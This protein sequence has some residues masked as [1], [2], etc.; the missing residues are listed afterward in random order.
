MWAETVVPGQAS[1]AMSPVDVVRGWVGGFLPIPSC[2]G[3][4]RGRSPRQ[5]LEDVLADALAQP[6]CLVTFSGGRDSSL[7]L[8]AA[9]ATARRCGLAPPVA[10]TERFDGVEGADERAWQEAVV[11]EL[12]VD[13]WERLPATEHVD[14]LGPEAVASLH[15]FGLLWPP[16]AHTRAWFVPALLGQPSAAGTVTG[17]LVDGEGGDE[18]LGARRLGP[19]LRLVG[20]RRRGGLPQPGAVTRRRAIR[21]SDAQQLVRGVAPRPMRRWMVARAVRSSEL[22]PWLTGPARHAF[23]ADLVADALAEPLNWSA[24]VRQHLRHRGVVVGM[25]SLDAVV[26]ATGARPVHPLLHP[27]VVDAVADIGGRLGYGGRAAA[28]ADCFGDL[29]PRSLLRRTDKARFNGAAFGPRARAFA[30]AWDGRGLP[31]ELVDADGLMRAW[32]STCPSALTYCALHAAWM[33]AQGAASL[34]SPCSTGAPGDPM[35]KR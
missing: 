13:D 12:G 2:Q 24:A 30:S 27:A 32:A 5:A 6:P 19:L 4:A 1:L 9:V 16:L 20:G 33:A 35:E 23:A 11:Q 29:L 25:R 28:L 15:R 22:A 8:A 21:C 3:E 26:A 14:L 17:T 18:V 34:C 10:V 31:V 7:L